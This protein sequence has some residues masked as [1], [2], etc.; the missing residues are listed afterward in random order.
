M[1]SPRFEW[2]FDVG[3]IRVSFLIRFLRLIHIHHGFREYLPGG[4]TAAWDKT[5]K[6]V[7]ARIYQELASGYYDVG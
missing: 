4:G 6:S 7:G 2:A 5:P 3:P 1:V